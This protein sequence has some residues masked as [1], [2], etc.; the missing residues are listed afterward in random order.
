MS[1]ATVRE[2][3]LQC[4][5]KDLESSPLSVILLRSALGTP[6]ISP[7]ESM[8]EMVEEVEEGGGLALSAE[9]LRALL[10]FA[11]ER[12]IAGVAND[13]SSDDVL[14]VVRDHF[15]VKDRDEVFV[16]DYAGVHMELLG[17]KRILGQTLSSTGMTIWRAAE[18]LCEFIA[19]D[20]HRFANKR[21][22]ELGAGLGM[23]SILVDKLPINNL[24]E[25][26][27]E[28]EAAAS[29]SSSTSTT[30]TTRGA[31][32]VATDGCP[33]TVDMLRA[34]MISSRVSTR[35]SCEQLW[36]GSEQASHQDF[37]KKHKALGGFDIIIAADVVYEEDQVE[38]LI[39]TVC[40]LLEIR[41]SSSGSSSSSS[42]AAAAA[43][44]ANNS[45]SEFLLAF[46]RRNVPIDKVFACASRYG[47]QWEALDEGCSGVEPIVR[48]TLK[49]E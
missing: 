12:G 6:H 22:C 4:N 24:K 17:V 49:E 25:E 41:R 42:T 18:H 8:S 21:V 11:Q 5:N 30:T 44:A 28:E 29:A 3:Q 37:V 45:T 7:A 40:A 27:E 38:P 36:W 46:A 35:M 20:V 48:F 32:V 19:N 47:L 1:M 10:E 31:V 43:A 2:Q 9:A 14:E 33:E 15:D 26:E 23:V 13:K 34:N 39:Q 16:K